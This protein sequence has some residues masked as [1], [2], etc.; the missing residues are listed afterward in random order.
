MERKFS[1]EQFFKEN[2]D[3]EIKLELVGNADKDDKFGTKILDNLKGANIT[4]LSC[5]GISPFKPYYNV[6]IKTNK[7]TLDAYLLTNPRWLTGINTY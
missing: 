2:I 5:M 4:V 1:I 6:Y 7:S 3:K